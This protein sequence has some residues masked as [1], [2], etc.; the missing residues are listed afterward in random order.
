MMIPTSPKLLP[1]LAKK[2]GIDAAR[3]ET[4]WHSASRYASERADTGSSAWSRLAFDHLITL[5]AAE[6]LRADVASMGWRPWG[7]A[8]QRLWAATLHLMDS[9]QLAG[10]RVMRIATPLA[11]GRIP[12]R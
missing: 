11:Y 1:W 8:Q 10:V 4:L 12:Q 2:A 5:I 6:S 7:R 9:A 3:A